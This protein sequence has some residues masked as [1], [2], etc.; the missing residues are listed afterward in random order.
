[1]AEN[2]RRGFFERIFR[3]PSEIELNKSSN[4]NKDSRVDAVKT[5]ST[6]LIDSVSALNNTEKTVMQLYDEMDQD[7]IISAALDL[8]ADNA[9]MLNTKTGHVASINSGDITFQDEI[10]DFLWNIFKVDTEAWHIVRNFAKYGKVFLDTKALNDG[11][12]WSFAIEDYPYNIQ[13]LVNPA[14]EIQYFAIAP[15]QTEEDRKKANS[16]FAYKDKSNSMEYSLVPADRYIMGLNS[17][18]TT[19]TMTV[20][21]QSAFT[22]EYV[23]TEYKIRTGRSI[24]ASVLSTW[25]TLN[26]MEQA[27]VTNRL[28]KAT[29]FKVVQVDIQD[30]TNKEAEEISAALKKA[31]KSQETLDIKENKYHNRLA[32][33]TVDDVVIITK[34][35]EKGAISVTPVGGEMSET[36]MRD[37]DYMRNKLF[38]GL[39][40]L[41]AYLGF[42]ETTPGGL[43]DS[44]LTK[45]DERVGRRV[46]RLQSVLAGILKDSIEY[47]WINSRQ[48]RTKH[49]M[50]DY[51]LL[52]GKVSTREEEEARAALVEGFNI[53]TSIVN[54]ATNELFADKIDRD[55]LF[56]FVWEDT[57]GID[58]AKID[59]APTEEDISVELNKI[60]K[61]NEQSSYVVKNKTK[62]LPIQEGKIYESA[63]ITEFAK[64]LEDTEIILE[65]ENYKQYTLSHAL[66]LKRF[67]DY[68]SEETYKDLRAASKTK[69]PQRL[70]KSKK[71][72]VRYTGIDNDNYITF[73]VTAE[74]PDKNKKAGR[75]TSYQTKVKLKDLGELLKNREDFDTDKD[76][77]MKA[78]DGDIA[79]SCECPAATYWGQQYLGTKDGYSI[80][81]NDIPPTVRI[82]TQPL[83]KHTLQMLNVVS[84]W[85]NTI[86]RDLRN[87][88]VLPK[89]DKKP[90][91]KE[92]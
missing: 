11:Y 23:D 41:K 89:I 79:V 24:L 76:L 46:L 21:A 20:R 38:A 37:I 2:K 64:L 54:L 49:N 77:V 59:A 30:S 29:Q 3:R 25:Q 40:M 50:P 71:S 18:E 55:K 51:T 4:N 31:F 86:I 6:S 36:P 1:M 45:L 74:D 78:I 65:D 70:A 72:I 85:W 27:L 67:K 75:P 52:M 39:G 10:N 14:N 82:P 16:I 5:T 88:G 66:R 17:R 87:K 44:T 8:F 81:K 84:F 22:D 61:L 32:P 7:A 68:L 57:L 90:K 56:R 42:E 15:E 73:T 33:P 9:T 48:G 12:E 58:T 43:G 60:D 47:Y 28:T 92:D 69:D 91:Q 53:T 83:C 13:A 35:G 34:R 26:V 62:K 63:S 80:D 19:G